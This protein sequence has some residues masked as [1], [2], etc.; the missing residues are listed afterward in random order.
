MWNEQRKR[1]I[2]RYS[3]VQLSRKEPG[4]IKVKEYTDKKYEKRFVEI[5]KQYYEMGY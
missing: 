1:K 3:A 2:N 5:C 4:T